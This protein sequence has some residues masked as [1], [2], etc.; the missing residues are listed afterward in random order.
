MIIVGGGIAGLSLGWQLARR[1]APVTLYEAGRIGQGASH[2]AAGYLQPALPP[3]PHEALEQASLAA[4][5]D[6]FAAVEADSGQSVD[7]RRDGQLRIG[8]A[9]DEAEMA[10]DTAA[11]LAAGWQ[12]ETLTA[13]EARALEPALCDQITCASFLP[14]VSWVDGRKLCA[15]LA[16]AIRAHGGTIVE[17]TP[18]SAI[19]HEKGRITGVRTTAQHHHAAAQVALAPGHAFPSIEGLPAHLPDSIPVRGVILTLAMPDPLITRLIKR[20][21]GILCPRSDGR[22]IVGVT[23]VEG[24]PRAFPDAGSVHDLL[25]SA[26]RAA[27]ALRDLPFIEANHAFRPFLAE[28]AMLNG[29]DPDIAG[30]TYALGHG[31]DGFLRAAAVS[32]RLAESMLQT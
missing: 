4:S 8:Y 13:D 1:G 2:V 3:S 18:V 20:P 28:E 5:P 16:A 21:D 31:A 14:Q 10:A 26:F 17:N 23:K 19:T 30:L 7:F 15:A 24:D 32:D 11:R 9:G 29:P 12:V 25:A 22:L 27:P 6:F